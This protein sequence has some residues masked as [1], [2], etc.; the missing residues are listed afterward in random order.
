MTSDLP[1]LRASH[2]DRERV[3]ETLRIAGGDGRLTAEELEDR[4]EAALSARTLGDLAALTADLP[5]GAP[6]APAAKDVLVIEQHGGKYARAGRWVVPKRIE[7]RTQHCQ[8]TL[9]F[10]AAVITPGTLRIDMDMVHGKLFIV[11]APGIEI[12]TDELTL[13]YSKCKLRSEGSGADP[14]L[15]IEF[16]GK[17]VHSK[18]IERRP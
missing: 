11:R 1:E 5:T 12:D 17:L 15:R 8:T 13:T 6:T 10:T 7:L 16:T 14:L 3:V 4:L 2:E 9:D 18:L